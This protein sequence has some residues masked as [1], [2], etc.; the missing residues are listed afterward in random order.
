MQTSKKIILTCTLMEVEPFQIYPGCA[1]ELERQK[2]EE[3]EEEAVEEKEKK[4]KQK[5]EKEKNEKQK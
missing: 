1:N 3:E 4:E 5:K 2:F